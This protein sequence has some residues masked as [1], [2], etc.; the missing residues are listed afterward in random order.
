M[1]REESEMTKLL[2]RMKAA[3]IDA[4]YQSEQVHTT[5][6]MWRLI[7]V[8]HSQFIASLECV[9]NN[10]E[11]CEYNVWMLVSLE[12]EEISCM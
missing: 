3:A 8:R 2:D 7:D 5:V 9:A 4:V 1:S 10:G 6:R 11:D 12:T